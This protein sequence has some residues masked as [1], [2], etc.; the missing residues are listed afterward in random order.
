M[1]IERARRQ[2]TPLILDPLPKGEGRSLLGH[3]AP[4]TNPLPLDGGRQVRQRRLKVGCKEDFAV[5]YMHVAMAV[6]KC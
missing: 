5:L 6:Y 1:T 2:L 4:T 3:P